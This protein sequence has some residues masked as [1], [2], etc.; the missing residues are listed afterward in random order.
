MA[1][2]AELV[3]KEFN[4]FRGRL[5]GFV[6]ACD[7]PDKQEHAM[8]QLVKSLSYDAEERLVDVLDVHGDHARERDTDR[9]R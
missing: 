7:L 5:L 9:R 6:E 1:N 2:T 3:A 8:K 4:R